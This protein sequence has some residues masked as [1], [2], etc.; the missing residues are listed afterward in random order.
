MRELVAQPSEL[1]EPVE[2]VGVESPPIQ[3]KIAEPEK[4]KVTQTPN[5]M[6][7]P[8]ISLLF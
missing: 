5:E 8:V 3:V 2:P 7:T 1:I 4:A 6:A